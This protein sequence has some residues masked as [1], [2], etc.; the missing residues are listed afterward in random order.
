MTLSTKLDGRW[1]LPLSLALNVFLLAVI[2]VHE[3]HRPHGPPHPEEMLEH[4]ARTLAPPDA[5]ILRQAFAAEPILHSE[6]HPP[7]DRDDDMEPVRQALRAEPF[8]PAA[9]T[10]AFNHG[11]EGRDARD[12]A[13]GRVLVQAATAMSA[14]GRHRLADFRGPPHGPPHGPPPGPPPDQR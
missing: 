13:V 5:A 7:P 9:L 11:H 4:L 12:Q 1:T 6:R 3:W 10:A 8:D 14:A 2:G